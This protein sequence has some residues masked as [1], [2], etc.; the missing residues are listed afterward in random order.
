MTLV[1]IFYFYVSDCVGFW[2]LRVPI[3]LAEAHFATYAGKL[4]S[5]STDKLVLQHF[6][7]SMASIRSKHFLRWVI[8]DHRMFR[9]QLS[10]KLLKR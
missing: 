3:Y 4:D 7:D 5:E 10:L 1:F 8:P 6:S 9:D 2:L